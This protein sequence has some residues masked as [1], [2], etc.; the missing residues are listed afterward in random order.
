MSCKHNNT[1]GAVGEL[2]RC[3]DCDSV[4]EETNKIIDV[5]KARNDLFYFVKEVLGIKL[6]SEQKGIVKDI[7]KGKKIKLKIWDGWKKA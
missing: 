4:L 3:S 5:V 6:T 7:I 2:L 1:Y